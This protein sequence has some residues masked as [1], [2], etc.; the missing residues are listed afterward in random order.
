[1]K[2]SREE[3]DGTR[4]IALIPT[5]PRP[6]DRSTPPEIEIDAFDWDREA[7]PVKKRIRTST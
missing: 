6:G 5:S 7:S 1:M 2:R 3:D 4:R